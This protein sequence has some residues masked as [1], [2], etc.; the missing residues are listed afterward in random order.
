MSN[1]KLPNQLHDRVIIG[2]WTCIKWI[3]SSLQTNWPASTWL[4]TTSV[5]FF[6]FAMQFQEIFV[7][8]LFLYVQGRR[9][10][11][12]QGA[13]APLLFYP[14]R[15]FLK[16]I[17]ENWYSYSPKFPSLPATLCTCTFFTS[18][19]PSN[20]NLNMAKFLE[21]VKISMD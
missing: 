3:I 14:P 16:Y 19:A 7:T 2:K 11:G 1:L 20:L 8:K 10:R 5:D 9:S 12:F 13:R 18:S 21:K 17:I 15:G 6:F 4:N